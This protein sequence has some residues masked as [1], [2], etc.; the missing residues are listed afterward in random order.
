[1]EIFLKTSACW[2][3][4]L[5]WDVRLHSMVGRRIESQNPEL[6]THKPAAHGAGPRVLSASGTYSQRGVRM[7]SESDCFR[8]VMDKRNFN[9]RAYRF[10]GIPPT[11][12]GTWTRWEC[13]V[14]Q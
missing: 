9:V 2:G 13:A 3:R 14:W 6:E 8:A 5:E 1:V 11:R 7:R 12:C 4:P 10:T